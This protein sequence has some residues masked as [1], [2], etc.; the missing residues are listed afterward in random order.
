[1]QYMI[2]SALSVLTGLG[3]IIAWLGLGYVG[4]RLRAALFSEKPVVYNWPTKLAIA[5]GAITFGL[6]VAAGW[7]AGMR[8]DDDEAF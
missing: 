3:V 4:V 7:A 5:G 2:H 6:V 1:M 8:T